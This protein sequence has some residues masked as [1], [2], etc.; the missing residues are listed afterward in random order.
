MLALLAC[1]A[2]TPGL[3][4]LRL[5][6]DG[7]ALVP[8]D[9]PEIAVDAEIRQRF[10]IQDPYVV[11]VW[12]S[13]PDGIFNVHTLRLVADLTREFQSL[14]GIDADQVFSL[15]TE[16]GDK[17]FPGT[18]NFRRVL[19]P[20]PETAWDC[21]QI[22][23]D[24]RVYGLYTGMLV[25]NDDKAAAIL[26]GAPPGADRIEL[27][28]R[29]KQAITRHDLM[30]EEVAVIG[31]PVAEALL[32]THLLQ[33][34][35]V[36]RFLLGLYG[37]RE[38]V[39]LAESSLLYRARIWVARHIGLVPLAIA[40]M[41]II[42]Y[43]YFKSLAA[44]VLPLAEVGA[45]LVVV[46]ALMGWFD[47]PIYLTIAVMPIIL[48]AAG[49]T[50]EIHVF[51]RY[52]DR[53]RDRPDD[54]HRVVLLDTLHEITRPVIM[55][56]VTTSLGFLA[57]AL[58]P[59]AP[60]QAFGVFTA[61][62]LLFCMIWSLTVIP[63][64]LSLLH[65]GQILGRK[66]TR[67]QSNPSGHRSAGNFFSG[68]ATRVIA[69][70]YAI[71]AATLLIMGLSVLGIRKVVVQDSWIDGFAPESEFRVAT[72]RFNEQFHGAHLLLIEVDSGGER[73]EGEIEAVALDGLWTRL[74]AKVVPPGKSLIDWRLRFHKLNVAVPQDPE[75]A[76]R[77]AIQN[78]WTTWITEE[79]RDGETLRLKGIPSHGIARFAL[80]LRDKDKVRFEL[81][82]SRLVQPA[83][84]H[85]VA[86]LE[87][88]IESHGRLAV[89]GVVGTADYVETVN[90][91]RRGR[92]PEHRGIPGNVE[93]I[94]WLWR[95]YTRMRGETRV[96][97]LID[98]T[99]EK[100]L[101]TVFLRG[102]NFVDT[103]ELIAAIR[104]YERENLAPQNIRL[105]LAGDV[106]VSQTL[107]GAIVGTQI[108][109]VGAAL[110]GDL[111]VTVILGRSLIFGLLCIVPSLVAVLLNF[112]VM[113]WL[114][115]PLGVA[116]SMF[117]S[118]TLG[119]GVDFA[120]HFLQNYR[121]HKSPDGTNRALA[122]VEAARVT[123]PAIFGNTLAVTLGFGVLMISQVPANARLAGL[124]VLSLAV[125]FAVTM[126]VLP[127]ILAL[128]RNTLP[129]RIQ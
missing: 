111:V 21:R 58:S 87:S 81:T 20:L 94:D 36:P 48:T 98:A 86:D 70:R 44:A 1:A 33:D 68:L 79:Q 13:H 6:T 9:A 11:A 38:S 116:T 104:Q 118:M 56:G 39:H 106:A 102:A 46:F 47:V 50:D 25:S 37:E 32:G 14:E 74:N 97:Q 24:L 112:A 29:L 90:Y 64:C 45:C 88:F 95:E 89:G 61:I 114:S 42:F 80:N 23:D 123:G 62:G 54:D 103:G 82:P 60:V 10:N 31:A 57:F 107:I 2:V 12:S 78:T 122:I 18:L 66:R 91:L 7:H 113:G 72:D 109:S 108:I 51:A 84:M 52:R 115:V 65:P 75:L 124:L 34:L 59:I 4:R 40:M 73:I 93:E 53:L 55:A 8:P 101:V 69:F 43:V 27:Y 5:R 100:S 67:H 85:A 22:R 30:N 19:E 92:K 120:I 17:V 76:R 129:L 63:A 99:F 117:S 125:C 3:L 127:A 83:I 49:V 77:H 41:G 119:L 26:V 28:G 15:A 16:F 96:R 128:R 121:E 35:G 105:S 126:L 110:A 71:L